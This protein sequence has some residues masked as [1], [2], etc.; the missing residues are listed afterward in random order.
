MSCRV[1]DLKKRG[2][3][4]GWVCSSLSGFIGS[5]ESSATSE[6]EGT[7]CVRVCV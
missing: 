3:Q 1:S 5:I 4:K 6:A 7:E 2:R